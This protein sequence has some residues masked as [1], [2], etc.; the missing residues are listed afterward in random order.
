MIL[1]L[2][3]FHLAATGLVVGVPISI[4]GVFLDKHWKWQLGILGVLLNL[5][6]FPVGIM[7]FQFVVWAWGLIIDT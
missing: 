2:W 5:A 7:A 6:V 1:A 3:L 4:A